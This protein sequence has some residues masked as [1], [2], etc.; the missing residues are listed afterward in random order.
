MILNEKD[1]QADFKQKLTLNG[2][3][4]RDAKNYNRR[5]AMD[6]ELLFEFLEKTQPKKVAT[7][8]GVLKESRHAR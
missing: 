4:D 6:P 5:F 8:K 1:Y 7:L 2:Y 3:R